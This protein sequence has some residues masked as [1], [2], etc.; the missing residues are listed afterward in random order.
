MVSQASTGLM[1]LSAPLPVL[2]LASMKSVLLVIGASVLVMAVSAIYIHWNMLPRPL[3]GIPY[4]QEAKNRMFGDIPARK[5]WYQS[6]GELRKWYQDQFLRHDSPIVQVFINPLNGNPSVLLCDHKETRDIL[7]RRHKEFDRG[8]RERQAFGALLPQQF[9][10]IQT[11]TAKFKF[12]KEL[13]KDLM[14]PGFLHDV[15]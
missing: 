8:A 4:N 2:G 6:H 1:G 7:F 3:P 11:P 10:S 9:L 14:L 13:M 12:H 5:A 15:S